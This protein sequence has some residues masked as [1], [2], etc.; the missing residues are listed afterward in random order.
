MNSGGGKKNG[1][2]HEQT[3]R[4]VF[5]F[6]ASPLELPQLADFCTYFRKSPLHLHISVSRPPSLTFLLLLLPP[7]HL[8]QRVSTS[9]RDPGAGW[10]ART[11]N[12][13]SMLVAK[14]WLAQ[15]EGGQCVG[16]GWG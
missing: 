8:H 15:R 11:A 12:G 10:L 2:H 5:A 16:M 1:E 6:G 13:D 14:G 3:T 4:G 7:S 9:S